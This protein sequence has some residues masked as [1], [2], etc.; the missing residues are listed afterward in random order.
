MEERT[1]AA[2][3]ALAAAES[4]GKGEEAFARSRIPN[5][6]GA[7]YADLGLWHEALKSFPP[8]RPH[9]PHA[10]RIFKGCGCIIVSVR[11]GS[12]LKAVSKPTR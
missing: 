10:K 4:A 8:S 3:A 5:T 1:N 7:F 12:S 6:Y 11:P 9:H 2:F